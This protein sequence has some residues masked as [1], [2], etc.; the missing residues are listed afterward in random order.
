LMRK[1]GRERE[2]CLAELPFS[3]IK[4]LILLVR[5]VCI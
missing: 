1:S 5:N 4:T 3:P 2:F